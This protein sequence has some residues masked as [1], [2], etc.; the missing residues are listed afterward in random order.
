MPARI[1][2]LFESLSRVVSVTDLT[3]ILGKDRTTVYRWQRKGEVP[4]VLIDTTWIIYR[5]EVKDLL[6]GHSQASGHAGT[7]LQRANRRRRP[8]TGRRTPRMSRPRC[9]PCTG[10]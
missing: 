7:I 6:S 5:D 9:Y 2:E 4:A 3:R 10:P 8:R 1:D